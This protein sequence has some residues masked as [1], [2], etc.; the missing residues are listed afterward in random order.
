VITD[1]IP[2]ESE[3]VRWVVVGLLVRRDESQAGAIPRQPVR[4]ATITRLCELSSLGSK[5][6]IRRFPPSRADS[7]AVRSFDMTRAYL[8]R[9]AQLADRVR[10]RFTPDTGASL[11]A[12]WLAR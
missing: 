11:K 7:D 12:A 5:D 6:S 8:N 10:F 3:F 9:N 1:R 4:D 2:K